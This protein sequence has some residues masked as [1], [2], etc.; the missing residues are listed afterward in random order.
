MSVEVLG[1][2]IPSVENQNVGNEPLYYGQLVQVIELTRD[3]CHSDV[4]K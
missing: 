3:H 1:S 2:I 4:L